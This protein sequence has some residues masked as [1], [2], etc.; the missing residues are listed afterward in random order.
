MGSA[1]R[2]DRFATGNRVVNVGSGWVGN[3]AAGQFQLDVY[4]EV[5]EAQ[6]ALVRRNGFAE[7]QPDI[8][9]RVLSVLEHAWRQPDEGI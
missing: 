2:L 9:R 7:G 4:G 6:Y 3:A 5:A 8:V 1:G